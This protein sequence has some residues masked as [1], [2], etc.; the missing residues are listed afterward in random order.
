MCIWNLT[1][2]CKMG[3]ISTT[4]M[5]FSMSAD[6]FAASV[7]K[8][9][10]MNKPKISEALK[11]GSIFGLVETLT[12]IIGW[13]AGVAASGFIESIDHWIAF[14]IL[15]IIGG[16]MLYES[17]QEEKPKTEKHKLSMLILTAIGTSIDA[18]AVGVTLALIN[19]NILIAATSIGAATFVMT[20]TGIMTGH[21]IGLK[22]G[23]IA[24][25]LGGICLIIIGTSILLDHLEI[26]DFL[27]F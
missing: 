3:I 13:I 22:S 27:G 10:V 11:V 18:M 16:K 6:A 23:K 12:P 21:Y 5:A 25:A 26:I 20:T 2:E 4:I 19:A 15:G 14:C 9:T 7:S 17:F 1:K 8:G 24:E